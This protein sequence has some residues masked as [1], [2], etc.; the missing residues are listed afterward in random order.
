MTAK[1]LSGEVVSVSDLTDDQ[2]G[3]ADYFLTANRVL[4]EKY[5]D[6]LIRN[7]QTQYADRLSKDGATFNFEKFTAAFLGTALKNGKGI[8][9]GDPLFDATML[10]RLAPTVQAQ[11]LAHERALV[12]LDI[13]KRKN[14]L[15]I[16][17]GSVVERGVDHWQPSDVRKWVNQ[18][19]NIDPLNPD[20]AP[21]A[22][23][24]SILAAAGAAKD[25][26]AIIM[27][28]FDNPESGDGERSL[29]QLLP[30]EA[31]RAIRKKVGNN[32]AKGIN[33]EA[34][35]DFKEIQEQLN[36][37]EDPAE[38]MALLG[39]V[40]ELR[41]SNGGIDIAENLLQVGM[42][43]LGDKSKVG[44]GVALVHAMTYGK[45]EFDPTAMRKWQPEYM[46][47]QKVDW[48]K[49]PEGFAFLI[50]KQNV[51]AEKF[52]I[53]LSAAIS[54]GTPTEM[55]AAAKVIDIL[56]RTMTEEWAL[57]N[58]LGSAQSTYQAVLPQ[59]T[60]GEDPI[61]IHDWR[62]TNAKSIAAAAKM[63]VREY[64][65]GTYE[66]AGDLLVDLQEGVND[67]FDN[68]LFADDILATGL[69]SED[70]R[71][72]DPRLMRTLKALYKQNWITQYGA[73]TGDKSVILKRTM[74][75]LKIRGS[76]VPGP[77][78]RARLTLGVMPTEIRVNGEKIDVI[79]IGYDVKNDATGEFENTYTG[80]RRYM[81]VIANSISG[82]LNLITNEEGDV[83]P[84]RMSL[85]PDN[86]WSSRGVYLLKV[87]GAPL[88]YPLGQK[89]RIH[90]VE[91]QLSKDGLEASRQLAA[92]RW[93]YGT[94]LEEIDR[95]Q[96]E[97][98]SGITQGRALYGT[99]AAP[100]AGFDAGSDD[101][102][103]R[104]PVDEHLRFLEQGGG[105]V[106][107]YFVGFQ[108]TNPTLQERQATRAQVNAAQLE[109][110]SRGR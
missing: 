66:N 13:Q 21:S 95:K 76:I 88:V 1:V 60:A 102:K 70:V 45:A 8:G 18:W 59:L 87:D 27:G 80:T 61:K 17:I 51:I 29:F 28:F 47:A 5:G 35:F 52:K 64:T 55:V 103:R 73:G 108:Y 92:A 56:S 94:F 78:G 14:D 15:S 41:N 65:G 23:V 104:V 54:G 86:E 58:L 6:D 63:G 48:R 44:N 11:Q 20:A 30:P 90:G 74:Q 62:V 24:G 77:N 75:Q 84:D 36:A 106:V 32:W 57:S 22:V 26:N 31:A 97:Q 38:I 43:K 72:D 16:N 69:F 83:D 100:P 67:A 25:A 99:A 3:D 96:L 82:D 50:G 53:E 46:K 9:T 39:R 19:R 107:G 7:F 98:A 2:M 49:D 42:K 4:G 34:R 110:S 37:T 10:A 91:I 33:E 40:V 68:G 81:E 12:K 105:I 93:D 79:R 109:E 71:V 89:V 85:D 101:K